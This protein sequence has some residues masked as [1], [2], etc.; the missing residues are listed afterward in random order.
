MNVLVVDQRFRKKSQ[1]ERTSRVA[2]VPDANGI[3][4]RFRTMCR[5]QV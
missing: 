1:V 2:V 4:H 5:I 3:E